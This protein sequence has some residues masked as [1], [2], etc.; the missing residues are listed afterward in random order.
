MTIKY[1]T[2]LRNALLDAIE[3]YAGVSAKLK[4]Y[5]GSEPAKTAAA[6]GTLLATVQLPS[7]WMAAAAS[8]SKAKLGTWASTAGAGG[9][10]TYFRIT[11]SADATVMQ[12]S[13]GTSGADLIVDNTTFVSGQAF[14]ITSFSLT[15]GNA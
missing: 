13:V 3:S 9:T 4:I 12:G 11:T 7:D 2:T 15:N 6:T 8:G 1:S 10:A 14:A 5:T